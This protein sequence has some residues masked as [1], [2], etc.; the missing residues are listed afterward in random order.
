VRDLF[1]PGGL[2]NKRS[3]GSGKSEKFDPKFHYREAWRLLKNDLLVFLFKL[4]S[5]LGRAAL[6]F[7]SVSLIGLSVVI[8]IRGSIDASMPQLV[9]QL[10][11]HLSRPAFLIGVGGLLAATWALSLCVDSLALSGIWGVFEQRVRGDAHSNESFG[12]RL[13]AGISDLLRNTT[14]HFPRVLGLQIIGLAAQTIVALLGA[15]TLAGVLLATTRNGAF[16]DASVWTRA[17][18]WALPCTMLGAFGLLV[19]LCVELAAAPLIIDGHSPGRAIFEAAKVVTRRFVEL[20][21][22]LLFAATLLLLPLSLYWVVFIV[23]SLVAELPAMGPA[24]VLFRLAA[25]LALF[26][27]SGIIAVL[28]KGALFVYYH[29]LVYRSQIAYYRPSMSRDAVLMENDKMTDIRRTSRIRSVTLPGLDSQNPARV[30]MTANTNLDDFLPGEYANI[31]SLD[32]IISTPDENSDGPEPAGLQTRR[33]IPGFGEFGEEANPAPAEKPV[34]NAPLDPSKI[35]GE[36]IFDS[37]N[38]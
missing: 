19:R 18:L 6:W 21:R 36:D 29:R 5:D 34:E 20:Y 30:D 27:S 32:E 25:D 35:S 14:R 9:A 31:V 37:E 16:A 38:D 15:M 13:I 22:L 2:F 10:A 23:Q 26:V 3:R 33:G 24:L 8:A 17:L 28:F 12:G 1:L 7:A 4:A 11:R